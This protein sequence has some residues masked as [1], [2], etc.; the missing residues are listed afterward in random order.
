MAI[1]IE[2][3]TADGTLRGIVSRVGSLRAALESPDPIAIDRCRRIGPDGAVEPPTDATILPDDLMLVVPEETDVVVHASWHSVSLRVGPYGVAGELPTMP[4]FDPGRA[5]ARPSR[6]FVL[7]RDAVVDAPSRGGPRVR[8]PR[9][10]VNR[11]AVDS[12]DADI[13]LGFFFPGAELIVRSDES[14]DPV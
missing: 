5:I 7:L 6:M 4:G 2:A 12:V 10:L 3:Y 11:Y 14:A 1:A 13:M 9:L 8:H